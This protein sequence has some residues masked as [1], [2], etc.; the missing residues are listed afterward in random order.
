MTVYVYAWGNNPRRAEL[1]GRRCVVEAAGTKNTVLIR[2]LD[3]GERVTT[4]RRALR[5]ALV[6]STENDERPEQQEIGYSRRSEGPKIHG[7]PKTD[8]PPPNPFRKAAAEE[9]VKRER[10]ELWAKIVRG[11]EKDTLA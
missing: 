4:S 5:A 10:H 7:L 6:E 3:N 11:D 2:F 1:K 9:R 8:T